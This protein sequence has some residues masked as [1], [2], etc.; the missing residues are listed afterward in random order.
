MLL[1]GLCQKL[2]HKLCQLAATCAQAVFPNKNLWFKLGFEGLHRSAPKESNMTG[3][4]HLVKQIWFA[5]IGTSVTASFAQEVTVREGDVISADVIN[6]LISNVSNATQ[7]FADENDLDGEWTCKTY[8]TDSAGCSQDGPLLYSKVGTL[9]FNAGNSSFN[10]AG[11]GDPRGCFTGGYTT[12]GSYSVRDG[13][14]VTAFGVYNVI[15]RSNNEFLWELNNANPPNGYTV[16]VRNDAPPRA[17]DNLAATD[18]ASGIKLTWSDQSINN[19]TGFRVERK[20][21]TASSTF[22]TLQSLGANVVSFTDTSPAIGETW[23]Y[24][25]FAYNSFGD[26]YTSSVVQKTHTVTSN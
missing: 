15:K 18:T 12:T 13:Y 3:K 4:P 2:C 26:A 23:Q 8:S 21:A 20:A 16:C 7:G 1:H 17:V 25:V 14:L 5:L 24:R 11:T 9:T 10:Y 19:E 6:S 22:T